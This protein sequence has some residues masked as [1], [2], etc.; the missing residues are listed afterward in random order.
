MIQ[1]SIPAIAF[2]NYDWYAASVKQKT[3]F[4]TSSQLMED[5]V[6]MAFSPWIVQKRRNRHTKNS[7]HR[8]LPR[9]LGYILIGVEQFIPQHLLRSGKAKVSKLLSMDGIPVKVNPDVVALLFSESG[10]TDQSLMLHEGDFVEVLEGVFGDAL[11]GKQAKILE[12]NAE[13]AKLDFNWI[14]ARV[15]VENLALV[16]SHIA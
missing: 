4:V 13:H 7:K 3:E 10:S 6:P 2:L 12:I 9:F 15:P 14:T 1:E 11:L 16:N 5:G 8:V